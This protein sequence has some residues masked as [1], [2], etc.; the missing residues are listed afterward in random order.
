MNRRVQSIPRRSRCGRRWARNL[1]VKNDEMSFRQFQ[2]FG[3][4]ANDIVGGRAL[5]KSKLLSS[6]FAY[7]GRVPDQQLVHLR[8]RVTAHLGEVLPGEC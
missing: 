1:L 3:A 6:R 4:I 7:A 5:T 2:A 8:L